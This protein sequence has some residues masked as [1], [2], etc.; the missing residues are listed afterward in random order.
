MRILV[1]HN[2]Y[3]SDLPSGEDLIVDLEVDQLRAQGHDVGIFERHSDEITL[4]GLGEVLG[5]SVAPTYPART[6]REFERQLR[7]E[8]PDIVHL[9]NVYP[10]ISPAVIRSAKRAQIPVVRTVHNYRTVC[11]KAT[12][13]R[14]GKRCTS[15][16]FGN[17][18]A[19][20]L[21]GCYRAS[22][23]QSAAMAL[24]MVAHRTSWRA[25]DRHI[26][27]GSE[28]ESHLLQAGFDPATVVVRPNGIPDPGSP[29]PLGQG[30]L[31]PAR[32]SAEKGLSLV[33]EAWA[34][35]GLGR[36]ATLTV[37]GDGPD[38]PLARR[39]ASELPGVRYEG[40]LGRE[41][42]LD[43]MRGCQTVVAAPR[44]PEPFGLTVLEAMASARSVVGTRMGELTQLVTPETGWLAE[45]DPAALAS[46]LIAASVRSDSEARGLAG[47]QRFLDSFHVE[48]TTA[49]LVEI[50]EDVIGR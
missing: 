38:A 33:L 29:A 23:A 18:A 24:S 31:F 14:D 42:V 22:R 34:L 21:Y 3:R 10:L 9:H 37:V 48:R 46:S 27:I 19:G 7:A 39:A 40:R 32:L 5:A 47:R 12:Q 35:S 41:G 43:Q 13:L 17:P 1:V 15:C 20:V 28:V 11:M 26:A 44:W 50:Y 36:E 16:S 25:V 30:F 49:Q 4:N 2:R 8:R 45:P 6:I